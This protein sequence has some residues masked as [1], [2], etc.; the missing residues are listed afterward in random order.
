MAL[1]E[2]DL[3]F[4]RPLWLRAAITAG[5][6]VWCGLEIVLSHDQLWIG[7]TGF[8]VAYCLY[9]F[10]WKWPK[11]MPAA[12]PAPGEAVAAAPETIAPPAEPPGSEPPAQP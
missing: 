9:N 3:K 2:S 10:F 6:A 4:F 1:N 11:Q 5:L 12:A 7:I 8:G